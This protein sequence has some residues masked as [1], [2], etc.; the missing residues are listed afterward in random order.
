MTLIPHKLDFTENINELD[1]LALKF[2][3]QHALH[4]GGD[5]SS[6]INNYTHIYDQIFKDL[7]TSIFN[8]LEVGVF[9]GDS[10]ALFREYLPYANI[11]GIDINLGQ[12]KKNLLRLREL[13]SFRKNEPTVA[14]VNSRSKLPFRDLQFHFI[15]DDGDHHPNAQIKTFE[16]LFYNYLTPGGMYIIEDVGGHAIP[17]D[18]G[19]LING[20]T[21]NDNRVSHE[22]R[23]II[24]NYF[25]NIIYKLLSG[26]SRKAANISSN[27]INLSDREL[28]YIESVQFHPGIIII[29]KRVVLGDQLPIQETS[30]KSQSQIN[31]NDLD[32]NTLDENTLDELPMADVN[33]PD[34]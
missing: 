20:T 10:L 6:L 26:I 32:E 27:Y 34:I 22:R 3:P 15:I 8:L 21:W 31:E 1:K 30:D 23:Q 19:I 12:Y 14:R 33:K 7:R 18:V 17:S 5:K 13:E 9:K 2:P 11:Y 29:K 25:S 4:T 24:I 16:N 28:K